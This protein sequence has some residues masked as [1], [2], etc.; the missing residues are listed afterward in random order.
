MDRLTLD[1]EEKK[2]QVPIGALGDLMK[3]QVVYNHIQSPS[4]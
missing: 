3:G 1:P 2:N 4:I